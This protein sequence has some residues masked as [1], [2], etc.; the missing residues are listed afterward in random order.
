MTLEDK[1]KKLDTDISK[2][3]SSGWTESKNADEKLFVVSQN[4]RKYKDS[5]SELQRTFP[6]GYFEAQNQFKRGQVSLGN[7]IMRI[8]SLGPRAYA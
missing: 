6:M 4:A 5:K 3:T 2:W 8:K 1:L 7:L